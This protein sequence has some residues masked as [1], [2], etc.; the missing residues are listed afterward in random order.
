VGTKIGADFAGRYRRRVKEIKGLKL[1]AEVIR[2][3]MSFNFKTL[4]EVLG[5][6]DLRFGSLKKAD[7]DKVES[8]IAGLGKSDIEA[9]ERNIDFFQRELGQMEEIAVEE[10]N[11][12]GKVAVTLGV[13]LSAVIAIIL[14]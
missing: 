14:I 8:F 9:Q 12:Y 13:A 10:S 1:A 5:Q 6:A 3:E 2:N 4:D 7:R 11:R